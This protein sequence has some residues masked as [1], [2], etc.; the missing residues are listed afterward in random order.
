MQPQVWLQSD[1]SNL[2]QP[3]IQS[4]ST[5]IIKRYN[6][7]YLFFGFSY[8]TYMSHFLQANCQVS[9]LGDALNVDIEALRRNYN[10]VITH[11]PPGKVAIDCRWLYKIKFKLNGV[12]DRF[13]SKFVILG[14]MQQQGMDYG[15]TLAHVTKMATVRS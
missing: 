5:I 14:C 12:M 11:L 2:A 10:W 4:V 3:F 13:K 15:K 6:L 9:T 1:T 8:H 7:I